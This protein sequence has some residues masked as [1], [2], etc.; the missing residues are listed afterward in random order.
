MNL[1]VHQRRSALRL[2]RKVHT[3]GEP[4]DEGIDAAVGE[5]QEDVELPARLFRERRP[6]PKLE[7]LAGRA[8]L[9]TRPRPD[10]GADPIAA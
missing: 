10:H 2:D 5:R 3:I 9:V 1:T 7:H 4:V 8:R 6:Q